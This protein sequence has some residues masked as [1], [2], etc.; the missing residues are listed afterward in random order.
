MSEI[1]L[2][3]AEND[4]DAEFTVTVVDEE[5]TWEAV[6]VDESSNLIL[7]WTAWARLQ[8]MNFC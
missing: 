7:L 8:T 6:S 3:V 4:W 5:W 1:P 2:N